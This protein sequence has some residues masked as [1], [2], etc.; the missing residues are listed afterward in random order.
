MR[1]KYLLL[2]LVMVVTFTGGFLSGVLYSTFTSHQ[3][4]TEENYFLSI[5]DAPLAERMLILKQKPKVEDKKSKV[6]MGY[7]QDFRDPDSVNYS[8]LTHVIFS[9][10]HPTKDGKLL[11]NG[12]TAM[13]NLR[14]MVSNAA[15]HDTKTMLAVGGWFHI[16]GGESYEYFKEAITNPVART[17]LVNELVGVV[18]RESLDGIDVDFEHPRNKEDAHNLLI[19]VEELNKQLQSRDKELSIAVNA[20]VHSVAGTEL[21]NVVFEPS[22]FAHVDFVNIMAYDGQWDGEYNAAN[23]SPFTHNVNIINYWTNLFEQHKISK[24]KLV[25]GVP[26]YGQPEDPSIKQVSYEAIINQNPK[27]ADS[28]K[29]IMN[30]TTYH[31]NGT[32]TVKQK[33]ELA[34]D[35][36]LGGMMVWETGLDAKGEHSLT[37]VILEA[38]ES[39]GLFAV[40]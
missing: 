6:L 11:L 38:L 5:D 2:V 40:K 3:A 25:L 8:D 4:E 10:A 15:K 9:F 21:H 18:D 16:N 1:I 33:I 14:K 7:V 26:L 29:T 37:S 27:N 22:M 30:G 39:N 31:Y 24:E 28:D 19:F 17:T 20:K 23:L 32:A 34:L 13:E 36:G 35:N 12:D